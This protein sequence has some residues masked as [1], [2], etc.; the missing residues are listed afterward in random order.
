MVKMI[1]IVAT[2]T[3]DG[4]TASQGANHNYGLWLHA[5]VAPNEKVQNKRREKRLDQG[6]IMKDLGFKF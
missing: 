4:L 1:K 2:L 5:I 6:K 3:G